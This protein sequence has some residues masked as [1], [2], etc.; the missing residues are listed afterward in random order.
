MDSKSTDLVLKN[1]ESIK[2]ELE[3][4]KA[5]LL[6]NSLTRKE[7]EEINLKLKKENEKTLAK[8]KALE[9]QTQILKH[10]IKEKDKNVQKLKD[11]LSQSENDKNVNNIKLYRMEK[12]SQ[13]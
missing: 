1:F 6:E 11:F 13:Y 8:V 10:D 9:G 12:N 7:M 2:V 5:S 3:R 4:T